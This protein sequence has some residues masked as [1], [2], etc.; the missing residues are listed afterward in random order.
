MLLPKTTKIKQYQFGKS[1]ISVLANTT[2]NH[3]LKIYTCTVILAMLIIFGITRLSVENSFIDFRQLV[4]E[5]V[6]DMKAQVPVEA[7]SKKFHNA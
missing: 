5:I 1:L 6:D 3:S 7:I 4:R 2:K